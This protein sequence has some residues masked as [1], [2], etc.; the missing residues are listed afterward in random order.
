MNETFE[1]CEDEE[2]CE[3][4][5]KDC[6]RCTRAWYYEEASDWF[7]EIEEEK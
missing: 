6:N 7:S 2:I 4:H 3:N 5:G 1:D